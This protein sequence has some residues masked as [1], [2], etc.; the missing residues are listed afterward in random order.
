M[1][2]RSACFAVL[3]FALL[4]AFPLAVLAQGGPHQPFYIGTYTRGE[5]EGIYM[6]SLSMEDGTLAPPKLA[7][8]LQNPSFLAISQDTRKLYSVGATPEYLE[9]NNKNGAISAFAFNEDGTLRLLNQESSGGGGPCHVAFGPGDNFLLI[10]N[11]GGG[12]FSTLPIGEE[13]QLAPATSFFQHEGKSVH[14]SRQKGPHGHAMYMVP[15]SDLALAVDLG[16]DKVMIYK[17]H[18]RN[19]ELKLHSPA[20]IP[21]EP[22]SGPRHLATNA[23]GDRVYVLNELSSTLDAFKF[24]QRTGESEHLATYPTL[25][26]DFEGNNTTAEIYVHR[27]G[28]WLYCSNRGHDSIATFRIDRESGTL[29]PLGHVSTLGKTPRHFQMDPL[30]QYLLVANQDSHNIVVFEIDQKIG[31]LKPTGNQIQ[32]HSPV[33]IEFRYNW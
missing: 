27:S 33:C 11:Y 8:E 5:S 24:N 12:S 28:K 4:S 32:V 30:G 9:K 17:M 21:I 7:A 2:L 18:G 29:T 15:G 31:T 14:E 19:G 13:G 26:E 16:L 23:Q 25:P 22:G 1:P 6:S 20:F 3:S 10:S